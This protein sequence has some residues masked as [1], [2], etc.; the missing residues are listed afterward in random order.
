MKLV[1]MIPEMEMK[2]LESDHPIEPRPA[3]GRSDKISKKPHSL[4][5]DK[6]GTLTLQTDSDLDLL[7]SRNCLNEIVRGNL[8]KMSKFIKS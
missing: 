8:L 6:K 4:N 1:E 3:R 5:A 7:V 2:K